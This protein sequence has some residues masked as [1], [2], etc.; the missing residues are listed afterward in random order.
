M[1]ANKDIILHYTFKTPDEIKRIVI[2]DFLAQ[3]AR[4]K[5]EIE[6]TTGKPNPPFLIAPDMHRRQI[7]STPAPQ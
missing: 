6:F 3:Q 7:L 5:G 4:F 2:G 1:E